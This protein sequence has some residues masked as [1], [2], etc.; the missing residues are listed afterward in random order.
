MTQQ[1]EK[2]LSQKYNAT[3]IECSYRGFGRSKYLLNGWTIWMCSK[4]WAKAKLVNEHYTDHSYHSSLEEAFIESKKC[5][6]S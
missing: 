4:G 2:A 5:I 6:T 1:K 3:S